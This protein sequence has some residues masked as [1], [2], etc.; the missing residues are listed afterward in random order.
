[1]QNHKFC[2][3][4]NRSKQERMHCTTCSQLKAFLIE[5]GGFTPKGCGGVLQNIQG[6]DPVGWKGDIHQCHMRPE[7]G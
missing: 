3:S 1:M 2:A 7:V 5:L 6:G 4:E